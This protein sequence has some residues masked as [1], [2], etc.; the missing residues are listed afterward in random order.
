MRDNAWKLYLGLLFLFSVVMGAVGM[1]FGGIFR[2]TVIRLSVPL[3]LAC[4]LMGCMT[5]NVYPTG[6][7]NVVFVT[8]DKN[9]AVPT[10][11][12]VVPQ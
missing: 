11:A 6:D 9:V 12:S 3:L 4:L 1:I 8:T 7:N 5:I 2:E 10:S